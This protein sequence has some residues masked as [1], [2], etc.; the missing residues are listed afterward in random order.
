MDNCSIFR[1]KFVYLQ[2]YNTIKMKKFGRTLWVGILTGLAFLGACNSN[3]GLT[4][5]ERE[6]LIKERDSIQEILTRREG[7]CVYGSPEII[8]A[9]GA[10][11]R[12]LQNQLNEINT[13][14]AEDEPKK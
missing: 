6:Q 11:T 8:Q 14:L 10:E 3:K 12:R 9:Y 13:R 4:K 2:R 7:S 1:K 5:A